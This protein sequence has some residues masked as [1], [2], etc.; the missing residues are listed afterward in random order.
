MSPNKSCRPARVSVVVIAYRQPTFLNQALAGVLAQE[1]E[2]WE[3]IVVDDGS[4]DDVVARY[5]PL[6]LTKS[7]P[8]SHWK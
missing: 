6:P 3:L 1:Y 2:D 7:E 8:K 4:G 5:T